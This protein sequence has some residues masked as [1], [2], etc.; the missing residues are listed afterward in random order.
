MRALRYD[1][2]RKSSSDPKASQLTIVYR[3][4]RRDPAKCGLPN[5]IRIGQILVRT[6]FNQVN[7]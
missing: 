5:E 6:F 4:W 3:S 1:H 7:A 2:S